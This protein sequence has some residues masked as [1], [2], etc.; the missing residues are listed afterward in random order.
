MVLQTEKEF[1]KK[2]STLP[3]LQIDSVNSSGAWD[4]ASPVMLFGRSPQD[5]SKM[6]PGFYK[7]E[8]PSR[9]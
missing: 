4:F 1:E 7:L 5:N 9:D 6:A 2:F 8:V 3:S